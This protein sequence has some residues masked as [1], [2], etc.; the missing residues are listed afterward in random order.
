MQQPK[1]VSR[2]DT[3]L[4]ATPEPIITRSES[5]NPNTGVTTYTKRWNEGSTVK[6]E[7]NKKRAYTGATKVITL[8]S[9]PKLT[10]A[11][12]TVDTKPKSSIKK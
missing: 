12:K 9:L 4:A 3:P 6:S 8:E 5:T 7:G 2:P 1:K 10:P 11:D